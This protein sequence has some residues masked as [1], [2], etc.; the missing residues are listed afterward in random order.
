MNL[1]RRRDR[2]NMEHSELFKHIKE[3]DPK[4]DDIKAM[5]IESTCRSN[6]ILTAM[7]SFLSYQKNLLD[8]LF[9]KLQIEKPEPEKYDFGASIRNNQQEK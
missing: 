2:N 5:L 1:P 8:F 4:I 6:N 9:D 7:N 3:L